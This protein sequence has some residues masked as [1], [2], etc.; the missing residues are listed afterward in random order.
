MAEGL[1]EIGLRML[2]K[3]SEN[4]RLVISA[5]KHPVMLMEFVLLTL[6]RLAEQ[7]E[8]PNDAAMS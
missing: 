1:K 7:V 4:A 3:L 2:D 8:M 6:I 5:E